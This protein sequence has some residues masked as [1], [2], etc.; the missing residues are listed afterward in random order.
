[1]A[2][3]DLSA[4]MLDRLVEKAG[5]GAPCPLALGDATALPFPE[6]AFGA[7]V[8]SHVFH[9]VPGWREGVAEL[10]RVVRPGGVVLVELTGGWAEIFRDVRRRFAGAAG[11]QHIYLGVA[12]ARDP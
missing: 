1:M 3:G 8:A 5:A 9:L 10:V 12:E 7:A 11:P 4:G 6:G 2:G